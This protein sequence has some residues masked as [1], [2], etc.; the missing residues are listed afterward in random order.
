M[1]QHSFCV[2]SEIIFTQQ[3]NDYH[4]GRVSAHVQRA[5]RAEKEFDG[6]ATAPVVMREMDQS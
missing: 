2:H 4:V 3:G 6:M 1:A 5:L